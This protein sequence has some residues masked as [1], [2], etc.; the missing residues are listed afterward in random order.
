[1]TDKPEQPENADEEEISKSERKRQMH[2]LQALGTKLTQLKPDQLATL[3]LSS[4]LLDAVEQTNKINKHEARRRHLQ[5]I[6]KL[7]R[8]EDDE[9]IEQIEQLLSKIKQ[10]RQIQ[11][12]ALHTVEDWRDRILINTSAE[13]EKFLQEFPQADRQW[14]RQTARQHQQEQKLAKPPAA[15]RKLFKYI[16]EIINL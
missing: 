3:S 6:G 9:T 16:E 2:A 8:K 11:A 10:A 12:S 5:Y 13:I 15:A 1:M 4:G 7:M 14:L